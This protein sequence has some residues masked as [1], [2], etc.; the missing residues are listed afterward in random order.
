MNVVILGANGFIGSHLSERIL[1]ETDWTVSALD[2]HAHHLEHCLA[3]PRFSFR[4][5]DLLAESAWIEDRIRAADVV[6]PLVGIAQPAYYVKNPLYVFELDFEQNLKIVRMCVTHN[7]RVLFPSTSEVYGLCPDK[8]LSED[9][10][11]LVLGPVSKMRWIYSCSKQMMDR[12]LAA[13][14]QERGLRFT[15]FRPFNWTGP[16]LDEPAD[17][18]KGTA[19]V[20]TQFLF[21]L[22]HGKP[23][24]L[25]G[26]G[27][28]RRSFTSIHDGIDALLSVVRNERNNLDGE[29]LNIG[30]PA[31]QA[32]VKELAHLV[33]DAAAAYPKYAP[34]AAAA[35]IADI[36][37]DDYYGKGYADVQHRVPSIAKAERLLGWRPKRSL[38]DIVRD[39]VH[40]YLGD[41]GAWA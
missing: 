10:S 11:L 32:S 8:E 20:I 18:A 36:P 6:L 28:Q 7:K 37:E 4:K 38:E 23:L 34:L 35:V 12:V 31:N 9:E 24:H 19:R 2:L 29:I 1:A 21:N 14:G 16:R 30:N 39:T 26:G 13:Y 40:Y 41:G 22:V 5:G 3:D 33:R 25:V 27:R 15:C 17:A